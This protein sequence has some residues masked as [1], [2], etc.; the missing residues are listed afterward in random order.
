[1]K[2]R[3]AYYAYFGIWVYLSFAYLCIF[4][5]YLVLHV[6]CIFLAIFCAFHF[7]Y[8][9]IFTLMH[10]Q[11]YFSI[12]TLIMPFKANQLNKYSNCCCLGTLVLLLSPADSSYLSQLQLSSYASENPRSRWYC[13]GQGCSQLCWT[14]ESASAAGKWSWFPRASC[15]S[16]I[17]Q[18]T[19]PPRC[20]NNVQSTWV[21]SLWVWALHS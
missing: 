20:C 3:H 10:I 19:L 8:N 18:I 14:V 1:M 2:F 16:C 4:L 7:E 17:C 5:A 13:L 11:V 12:F 6:Q 15:T 21:C 9:G